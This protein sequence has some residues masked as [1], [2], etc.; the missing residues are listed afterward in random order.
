MCKDSVLL[1]PHRRFYSV[2][3]YGVAEGEG[4]FV[5]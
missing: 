4:E 2:P 5:F 1:S 3:V